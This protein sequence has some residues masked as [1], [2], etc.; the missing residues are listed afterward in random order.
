MI[1]KVDVDVLDVFV[2]NCVGSS[3][4]CEVTYVLVRGLNDNEVR[5]EL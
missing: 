3:G 4:M 5:A 2:E 1:V